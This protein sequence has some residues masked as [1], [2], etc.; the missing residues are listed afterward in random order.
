[1]LQDYTL[2]LA[3]NHDYDG[4]KGDWTYSWNFANALIFT[5]TIMTTIGYGHIAPKTNG[6]QLF[7]ILYAMIGTPMLLIF[8]ANIGDGMAK[9]F[10]FTYRLVGDGRTCDQMSRALAV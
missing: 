3:H 8:L 10:T 9:V 1:M 2:D 6:G 4:T 7:T 5:V